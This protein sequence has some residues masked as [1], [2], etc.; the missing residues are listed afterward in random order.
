MLVVI[1]PFLF[2]VCSEVCLDFALL[3]LR[4]VLLNLCFDLFFLCF[5]KSF[6]RFIQP[7]GGVYRLKCCFG[8]GKR[9]FGG[10]ICISVNRIFDSG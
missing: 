10:T 2:F 6:L 8:F 3:N 9:L 7:K 5:G 4:F 1:G